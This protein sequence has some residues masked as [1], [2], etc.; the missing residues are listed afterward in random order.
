MRFIELSVQGAYRIEIEPN[1]DERGL[2]AR[3][4]CVEEFSKQELVSKI[5]QCS[6]SFNERS[7]TLRG[8]HFQAAPFEEAKV[9][10]CTS[11]AIYDVVLDLRPSSPTFKQWSAIELTASSR[12]M[13][14]I[15]RGVAHGFQTLTN[16]SE[17]L[18]M[19]SESY[20]P[21]S[22]RGVRWNDPAFKV[23]WPNADRIISH[24]D[25]SYPDFLL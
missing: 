17:T 1:R 7:G 25:Q 15:P 12:Q 4:W 19:V 6:I 21:E 20:H 24:K 14:Y 13:V 18:Y 23:Q 3:T 10:R 5:V 22:A 11:G 2:F 16:S 8:L 9:V